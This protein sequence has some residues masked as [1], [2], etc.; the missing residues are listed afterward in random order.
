MIKIYKE[1]SPS[2]L[3]PKYMQDNMQIFSHANFN[4]ISQLNKNIPIWNFV[5]IFLLSQ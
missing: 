4:G 2:L 1:S 5:L 3:S